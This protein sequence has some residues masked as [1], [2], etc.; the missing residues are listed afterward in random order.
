M[1]RFANILIAALLVAAG[2]IEIFEARRASQLRGEIQSLQQQQASLTVQIQNLS[3]ERDDA[4]NRLAALETQH[5]HFEANP[6]TQELLQLR[7]EASRLKANEAVRENDPT[8]MAADAWRARVN[9]L[10]EYAGQHPDEAIPEFQYLDAREWL[11]A[12]DTATNNPDLGKALGDLRFQ[13]E[14][15]FAIAMMSALKAYTKANNG[16]FPGDFS[17]LQPYCGTGAEQILEQRYQIEAVS[18]LDANAQHN[19]QYSRITSDHIIAS[20]NTNGNGSISHIAIAPGAYSY[21]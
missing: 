9:Q 20:K 8:A 17:Q 15:K 4:T 6:G 2:V 3:A 11:V 5:E 16:Q 1:K 14:A 13:A 21:F 7:G 10:K 19:I 18:S 12:V